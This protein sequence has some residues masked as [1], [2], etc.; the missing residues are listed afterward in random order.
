M[1]IIYDGNFFEHCNNKL[2]L[3]LSDIVLHVYQKSYIL[4]NERIYNKHLSS[5]RKLTARIKQV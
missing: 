2:Y 5:Q 4:V 3:W 1:E